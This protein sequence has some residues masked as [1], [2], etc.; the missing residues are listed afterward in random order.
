MTLLG[1]TSLFLLLLGLAA[2]V[3]AQVGDAVRAFD[4]G[5]QRYQQGDYSG[6]LAA[7]EQALGSGY[8]SG[9]L[10]YNMGNAYYRLDEIGHAIRY[11]ERARQLMPEDRAL[12]HNLDIARARTTDQ[13]SQIPDPFWRS[14][15]RQLVAA[16][17]ARG[18]FVAGLLLYVLAA[19]LFGYRLWTGRRSP[20]H[21]RFLAFSLVTAVL[22]VGL[23]F[24]ASVYEVAHRRAVVL[25]D[26]IVLRQAPTPQAST[27][28]DLHEG[29][30][31]EVLGAQQSWLEVRLPN[32]ATGWIEAATV[33]EI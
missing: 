33:G 11:Y 8:A 28:L 20:W 27:E 21:R 23:A 10:Y 5:N 3:R 2:P 6:A 30:V 1:K 12:L 31:V 9:A 19:T 25:A 14:W 7:Y 26:R 29:A 17:G 16:V 24:A 22:L 13:F 18:L 15:W 4:E 32:G